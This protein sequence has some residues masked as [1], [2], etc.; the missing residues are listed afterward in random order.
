MPKPS[1]PT[2]LLMVVRFLT[3]FRT[4]ARIR[5][6][7]MPQRPKP[8]TMM[9]APSN[10]SRMAS[11]ALA[12]T[13][14][15]RKIL[16]EKLAWK[17]RVDLSADDKEASQS[18]GSPRSF[19]AQKTLVQ[20]DNALALRSF[21]QLAGAL[22]FHRQVPGIEI[23]TEVCQPLLELGDGVAQVLLVGEGNIAPH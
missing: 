3:P 8:P 13:L 5:F 9:T 15:T 22:E 1:T 23:L 18:R 6:S 17:C 21:P 2:L 12:T 20:D 19:T 4:R 7:G 10:T 11:S 16:N 14:C